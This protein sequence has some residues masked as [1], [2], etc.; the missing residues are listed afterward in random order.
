MIY[1]VSF[2]VIA[3]ETEATQTI[4]ERVA[5]MLSKDR[6]PGELLVKF[7][8]MEVKDLLLDTV[9]EVAAFENLCVTGGRLSIINAV[10]RLFSENRG[11]Y[12]LGDVTGDGYITADDA[13]LTRQFI[14]GSVTLTNGQLTAA[15]VN[16]DSVVT[17]KDY[18]MTHRFALG[19]FYFPPE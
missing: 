13:T 6:V 2:A 4:E 19:T 9:D 15:D 10:N 8:S 5:E 14:L 18:M 11:A 16:K 17:S 1:S 7:Y 12:S 3:E